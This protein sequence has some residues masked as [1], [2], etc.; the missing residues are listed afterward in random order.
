MTSANLNLLIEAGTD[1]TKSFRLVA[2][3]GIVTLTDWVFAAQVR[4][5][6]GS[7]VIADFDIALSGDDQIATL[8]LDNATTSALA[9][10][11]YLWDLFAIK[12]DGTR[13]R[14]FEGQCTVLNRITVYV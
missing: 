13:W 1:F 12:P 6:P 11:R 5:L 8:S 14:I 10:G 9:A 2:R 4:A 3:A 7:S